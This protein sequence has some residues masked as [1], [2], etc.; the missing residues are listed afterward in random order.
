MPPRTKIKLSEMTMRKEKYKMDFRNY[1]LTDETMDF[2]NRTLHRIRAVRDIET[3]GVKA[4]DLG[5]WVEDVWNLF[6]LEQAWVADEA[7]VY[8]KSYV[9][10]FAY[11]GGHAVIGESVMV[12]DRARVDG[13]ALVRGFGIRI[14][15][16]AH[17]SG[18]ARVEGRARIE[19]H[20]VVDGN[21]NVYDQPTIC[22][23]AHVTGR[24]TVKDMAYIRGNALVK[25]EGSLDGR[26][27]VDG[28]AVVGGSARLGGSVIVWDD[29]E[30]AGDVRIAG[31]EMITGNAKIESFS[32]LFHVN[33]VL[34]ER[35]TFYRT[36]FGEVWVQVR[37]NVKNLGPISLG[38][39]LRL[40]KK[41]RGE[42]TSLDV[43]F[44]VAKAAQLHIL[45]KE[46]IPR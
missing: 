30:I 32:D 23:H 44:L 19:G 37:S 34:D 17:V 13:D 11:V 38:Q 36:T 21:A 4:G 2:E 14:C 29:A 7:K 6:G 28:N 1:E 39:L 18:N 45:G 24:A 41:H 10:N 22:G 8:G 12:H 5:G 40:V 25:D 3:H 27:V 20:A 42:A 33:A 16:S 26:A 15:D 43:A 35:V 46:A 31:D 9:C